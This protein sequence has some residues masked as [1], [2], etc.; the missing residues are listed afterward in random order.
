[1]VFHRLLRPVWYSWTPG[2]SHLCFAAHDRWKIFTSQFLS[3]Y[4][5]HSRDE[6]KMISCLD[7]FGLYGANLSYLLLSDS[8]AHGWITT[9]KLDWRMWLQLGAT[10]KFSTTF[11]WVEL[12][13]SWAD[14][15]MTA[16]LPP[17]EQIWPGELVI[18]K[19]LWGR[20]LG[21]KHTL[22]AHILVQEEKRSP[23]RTYAMPC[24][25]NSPVK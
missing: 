9:V 22:L 14:Y 8:Y 7:Y 16:F 4:V 13:R 5:Y 11:P 24:L 2:W 18:W 12:T 19:R 17:Q 21:V 3:L 25:P 6:L 15:Q 23:V 1:M 10:M 20:H